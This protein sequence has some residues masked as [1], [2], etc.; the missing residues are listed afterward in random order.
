MYKRQTILYVVSGALGLVSILLANKGLLPAIILVVIISVFVIGGARYLAGIIGD[1]QEE[2]ANN[3][4][5]Q[6]DPEKKVNE[7]VK[8]AGAYP[9]GQT[10]KL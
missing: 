6:S 5:E 2:T 10:E 1:K 7:N 9:S 8:K 3:G 4:T